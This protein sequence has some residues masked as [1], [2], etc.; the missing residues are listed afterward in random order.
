MGKLLDSFL[1]H[2]DSLTPEEKKDELAEIN[3]LNDYIGENIQQDTPK[4]FEPL[5]EPHQ[6]WVYVEI[7][8]GTHINGANKILINAE[9][10]IREITN[11]PTYVWGLFNGRRIY[12]EYKE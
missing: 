10:A 4:I 7:P 3:K 1:K 12:P 6:N 5:R 11:H 2:W 8:I 9:Q